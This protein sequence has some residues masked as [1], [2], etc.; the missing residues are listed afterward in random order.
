MTDLIDR[1][2]SGEI[3]SFDDLGIEATRDLSAHR[4][5]RD[6]TAELTQNLAHEIAG[7]PP[8]RRPDAT[9]EIPLL[10][11][12]PLGML[13]GPQKSPPPLPKPKEPAETGINIFGGLGEDLP[14]CVFV[15][16]DNYLGRHR[17]PEDVVEQH[18]EMRHP[19]HERRLSPWWAL[20]G[21]A[22]AGLAIWAGLILAGAAV[23]R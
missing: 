11:D 15:E 23:I 22:V 18:R 6:T 9:G 1:A 14:V 13:E 16:P 19:A 7:L 10:I 4:R 3:P 17:H 2:D 21:L 5:R 20:A 12:A 8:R